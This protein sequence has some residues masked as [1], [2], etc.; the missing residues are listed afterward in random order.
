VVPTLRIDAEREVAQVARVKALR[1]RRD[2]PLT[3]TA[4]TKLEETA[5]GDGNLLPVILECVEAY[6]TVGE[7]SNRLRRV[8]GEYRETATV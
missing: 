3:D 4:L 2:Q 5:N 7:I 1:D 6:A 8:W